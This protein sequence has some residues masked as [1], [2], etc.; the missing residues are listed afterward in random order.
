MLAFRTGIWD[1]TTMI[2]KTLLILLVAAFAGC[3][4][5]TRNYKKGVEYTY[6]TETIDGHEFIIY[7]GSSRFGITLHPDC[8]KCKQNAPK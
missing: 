2:K 5:D 8:P 7:N 1:N 4:A 3:E 6:F